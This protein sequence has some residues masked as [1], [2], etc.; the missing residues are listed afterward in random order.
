MNRNKI[1]D[2]FSETFGL[3]YQHVKSEPLISKKYITSFT[4]SAGPSVAIEM[5]DKKFVM[6]YPLN[7]FV[8]Q[9][10]IRYWDVDSVGDKTHLSFFQMAALIT[11]EKNKRLEI[12]SDTYKFI[13]DTLNDKNYKIWGTYYK[14]GNII[15][16]ITLESD[17]EGKSILKKIGIPE[18]NIVAV[19]GQDGFT[20]NQVWPFGG[21]KLELYLEI[22]EIKGCENCF[23]SLCN[24]GR[25]IEISSATHY[26]YFINKESNSIL[27]FHGFEFFEAAIG[28]E[29]LESVLFNEGN[30][31]YSTQFNNV[32]KSVESLNKKNGIN[33]DENQIIKIAD[34][35]RPLIFLYNEQADKLPGRKNRGR[36]WVLNKFFNVLKKELHFDVDLLL[37]PYNATINSY[38]NY[39]QLEDDF[40]G[41]SMWLKSEIKQ[42]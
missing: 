10:C 3:K 22:S 16:K 4:S 2:A 30:I 23:P 37:L 7:S 41:F 28:I 35:V 14:G 29:R 39:F 5:L 19:S 24:C 32:L 36:H 40:K 42:K 1:I 11:F 13:I 31:I 33:L 12:L 15:N 34:I 8:T 25:F 26:K 27:P 9:P 6:N 21:Y 18:N 17:E 38:N 20:A